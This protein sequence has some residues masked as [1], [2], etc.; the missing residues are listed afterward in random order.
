MGASNHRYG[1]AACGGGGGGAG[2]GDAE[3]EGANEEDGGSGARDDVG[4]TDVFEA[5]RGGGGGASSRVLKMFDLC[6]F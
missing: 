4:A 6:R 5:I 3:I 1:E 2:A